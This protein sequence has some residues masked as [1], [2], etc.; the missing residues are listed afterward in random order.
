M[1]SMCFRVLLLL[2]ALLLWVTPSPSRR[3]LDE[4]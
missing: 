4:R 1:A 3:K 2:P